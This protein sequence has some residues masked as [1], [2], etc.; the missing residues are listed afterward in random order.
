MH[1]IK[2]GYLGDG[3]WAHGAF[4]KI[5]EDE[6]LE[7]MFVTVRYDYRDDVLIKLA[8]KNDIPVELSSNINSEAYI[9][10]IEKYQI[11]LLVSMSF[12]QIFK[13]EILK[14][15]PMGVINCHAGKLPFYRGRNILNWALINDEKEFGITVHY[16]DQGIDT[17]DIILQRTYPITDEDNYDTLLRTAYRECPNILYDAIKVIQEDRVSRKKQKDIHPVGMY[18]GMRMSGDEN[19]DWNQTSRQIFNFVRAI[20]KPGPQARCFVGENEVCINKVREVKDAISY[21][22]IPGQI[23]GKSDD[24]FYVKTKDTFIEVVEY[25]SQKKLKIGDRL[26]GVKAYE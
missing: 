6:T 25:S 15:V 8:K 17:G 12:N 1:R 19:L 18:C 10:L 7:I 4:Q 14:S 13:E 3:I 2:I 26:K 24:G 20:C 22:G 23:I 21:I 11:D 5:V 9:A 16:V